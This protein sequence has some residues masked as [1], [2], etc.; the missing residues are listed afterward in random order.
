M[1]NARKVLE[2]GIR[3]VSNKQPCSTTFSLVWCP[4]LSSTFNCL[5]G[6]NLEKIFNSPD[7]FEH[8]YA[9]IMSW[10]LE[11]NPNKIQEYSDKIY[12]NS[13]AE[14]GIRYS[15]ADLRSRSSPGA[16]TLGSR[17][18]PKADHPEAGRTGADRARTSR[19][20]EPNLV[21]GLW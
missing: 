3:G 21:P 10:I 12:T 8:S 4:L 2:L 1:K 11:N 13:A 17:S 16:D 9:K 5:Q 19:P 7:G 6:L 15:R 20:A 14:P 18:S